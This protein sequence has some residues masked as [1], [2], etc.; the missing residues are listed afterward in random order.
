MDAHESQKHGQRAFD[1]MRQK[2]EEL[3]NTR[4]LYCENSQEY[5]DMKNTFLQLQIQYEDVTCR[6]ADGRTCPGFCISTAAFIFI[7]TI[8]L[9]NSN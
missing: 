9:V 5:D 8:G 1:A 6:L 4:T 3:S 2:L 7:A